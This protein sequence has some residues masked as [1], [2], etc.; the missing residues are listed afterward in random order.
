MAG[1]A[2]RATS[3]FGQSWPRAGG[4]YPARCLPGSGRMNKNAVYP[5]YAPSATSKAI[6]KGLRRY[7][8]ATRFR[9]RFVNG[10]IPRS[11][12]FD[13]RFYFDY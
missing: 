1:Y 10:E 11:D 13:A 2:L 5:H 6:E 7:L 3:C 8:A 4:M 9:P 12:R